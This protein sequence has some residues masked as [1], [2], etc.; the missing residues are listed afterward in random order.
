MRSGLENTKSPVRSTRMICQSFYNDFK[1]SCFITAFTECYLASH[2]HGIKTF[3]VMEQKL[4]FSISPIISHASP[5]APVMALGVQ[6][7][8]LV[9]VISGL[10]GVFFR[11]LLQT[12]KFAAFSLPVLQ[13]SHR[14]ITFDILLN[15]SICIYCRRKAAGQAEQLFFS[16][17]VD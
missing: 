9:S 5:K 1:Y 4:P 11:V 10:T 12:S 14:N 16:L 13:A 2:S 15:Q 6:V 7:C 8:F 17:Q 3:E